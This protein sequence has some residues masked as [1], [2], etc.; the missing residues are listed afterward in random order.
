METFATSFEEIGLAEGLAKGR[1]E[2][3]ADGLAEGLADGL[4][5]GRA[6]G[7]IEIVRRQL[8]RKIGALPDAEQERIAALS[9]AQVLALGEA[10]LD[11][12]SLADL[13]AWLAA[14]E[15]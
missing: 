1:T 3:R 6:E 11:F 2:G 12:G 7:Q 4:A 5:K 8:T 15:A 14:Q 10:L 9:A 13:T